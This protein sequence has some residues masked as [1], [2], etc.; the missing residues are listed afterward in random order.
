MANLQE[1]AIWEEGIYQFEKNDPVQGGED[2]ID[3]RPT[4]QLAN[5]TSYL[6]QQVAKQAPIYW[7][8][9]ASSAS[10]AVKTVTAANFELVAGATLLVQFSETNTASAIAFNVSGTGEKQIW[11]NN[12]AIASDMLRSGIVYEFIY[13]GTH[14]QCTG[15]LHINPNLLTR[16]TVTISTAV[17]SGGTVTL[18]LSYE[19]GSKQL[20]L[21][22]EGILL[23][24]DGDKPNYAE[25]GAVGD[26]VTD[27]T[28]L[29]NIPAG[30]QLTEV[31]IGSRSAS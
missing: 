25:T 27:V 12:K 17:T 22:C 18:P 28:V 16:A 7:C 15:S 13:D 19:N 4:R 1:T 30:L 23:N 21:Y 26:K 2:G 8:P 20:E 3:N 29:F 9:C 5:R 11:Y 14:W 6:K 31:L 10:S 24:S